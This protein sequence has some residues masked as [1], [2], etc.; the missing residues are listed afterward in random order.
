MRNRAKVNVFQ[1]AAY[2]HTPRQPG[3]LHAACL[4]GL[5]NHMCRG[6]AFSREIS[7][8]NHFLNLALVAR[9]WLADRIFGH[10]AIKQFLQANI[11]RA[12]AVQRAA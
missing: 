5:G 6:F 12:N 7:R 9:Q 10:D 3:D 4:Q 11:V 2:W 1:L 8:Q